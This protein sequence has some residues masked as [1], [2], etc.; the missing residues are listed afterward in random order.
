MRQQLTMADSSYVSRVGRVANGPMI[1]LDLGALCLG[2][3]NTIHEHVDGAF[4]RRF[5]VAV[6]Y[7]DSKSDPKALLS[8]H[9]VLFQHGLFAIQLRLAVEVSR[10]WGGIGFVRGVAWPSRKDIISGDVNHQNVPSR[11]STGKS[12]AG[13]DIE[14]SGRF[15]VL[16]HLVWE[17]LRRTCRKEEISNPFQVLLLRH[18]THT[19]NYHLR[20]TTRSELR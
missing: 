18:S 9:S 10:G 7:W 2:L 6:E 11:S 8:S 5:C 20:S 14:S 3:P 19:M 16:V 13:S 17:A 1:H 15:W 4:R 12:L